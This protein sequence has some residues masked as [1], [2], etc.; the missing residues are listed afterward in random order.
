MHGLSGI[1][2]QEPLVK[3]LREFAG[4]YLERGGVPD[5]ILLVGSEGMGKRTI[6]VAFAEELGAHLT[7]ASAAMLEK[8]ET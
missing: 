5:H 8:R 3:R 6:A 1:V 4:V 2:G 7:L